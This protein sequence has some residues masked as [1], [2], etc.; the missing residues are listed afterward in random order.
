MR[1]LSWYLLNPSHPSLGLFQFG[2]VFQKAHPAEHDRG[3]S[4]PPWICSLQDSQRRSKGWRADSCCPRV[5]PRGS[6]RNKRRRETHPLEYGQKRQGSVEDTR[7]R[8]LVLGEEEQG[9]TV[10]QNCFVKKN[11]MTKHVQA[12]SPPAS[13]A[14]LLKLVRTLQKERSNALPPS[15]G[16]LSEARSP[17]ASLQSSRRPQ[18]GRC[19]SHH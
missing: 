1:S 14:K 7:I 17:V 19:Q 16:L 11:N 2:P 6:W 10:G 4:S 13:S 12:Q 5:A 8:G 3:R 18:E 15:S 9:R